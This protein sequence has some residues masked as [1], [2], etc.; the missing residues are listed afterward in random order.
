M[1]QDL[2]S[3][4]KFKQS[5]NKIKASVSGLENE[6]RQLVFKGDK[7]DG[8]QSTISLKPHKESYETT[9]FLQ[10]HTSII[11]MISNALIQESKEE[12]LTLQSQNLKQCQ[13][14]L[15]RLLIY[16]QSCQDSVKLLKSSCM[17]H[18]SALDSR[19]CVCV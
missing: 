7:Q 16:I 9:C 6:E 2:L 8:K 4:W 14:I 5:Q 1:L 19:D 17:T 12:E 3:K 18:N 15:H 11:S 13:Y 10:L